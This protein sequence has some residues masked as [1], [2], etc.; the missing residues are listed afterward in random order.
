M[1]QILTLDKEKSKVRRT[2]E[3]VRYKDKNTALPRNEQFWNSCKTNAIFMIDYTDRMVGREW[4][5]P[6]G[7]TLY[8]M[9]RRP[10]V[11]KSRK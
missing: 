9:V 1:G 3:V 4:N 6:K 10:A 2:Q 5:G 8:S 11:E 7:E